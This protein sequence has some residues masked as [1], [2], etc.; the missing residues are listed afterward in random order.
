MLLRERYSVGDSSGGE[1]CR[2]R[3]AG[4]RSARLDTGTSAPGRFAQRFFASR[5][6][7]AVQRMQ[8]HG[9]VARSHGL[10]CAA[11]E[12]AR[13]RRLEG[14][15]CNKKPHL[16]AVGL[17]ENGTAQAGTGSFSL[18]LLSGAAGLEG[19]EDWS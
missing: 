14:R 9:E 11:S 19:A 10:E 17:A 13:Q 8:R 7:R 4:P 15:R 1:A 5:A 18:T 3:T 12:H 2:L 16:R 6:D